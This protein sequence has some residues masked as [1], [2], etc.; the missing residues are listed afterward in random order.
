MDIIQLA[1][2]TEGQQAQERDGR[3]VVI[4]HSVVRDGDDT[5][6]HMVEHLSEVAFLFADFVALFVKEITQAIECFVEASIP[7]ALLVESEGEFLIFERIEHVIDFL[8][9]SLFHHYPHND[10]HHN[11]SG[12]ASEYERREGH[13]EVVNFELRIL[14][15]EL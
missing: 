4:G 13:G 1:K 7:N 6:L 2:I 10:S 12:K 11:S 3:F 8:L 5:R 9:Q 15:Y 14:N